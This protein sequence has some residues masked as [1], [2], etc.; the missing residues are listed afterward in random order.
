MFAIIIANVVLK[1][2]YYLNIEME[3]GKHLIA[4]VINIED[5]EIFNQV[6][7][8][9][10]LLQKIIRD[11]NLNVVGEVHHHFKPFGATCIFL[12]SE[13]YLSIHTYAQLRYLTLDLYCC[14]NKIN[15]DDVC[16]II[17][18]YFNNKCIIRKLVINR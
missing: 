18:N 10:Q 12:L 17:I 8:I 2:K 7:T 3:C 9:K 11:M 5:F 13:S 16:E 14:N 15:M 1:F 6:E 4:D